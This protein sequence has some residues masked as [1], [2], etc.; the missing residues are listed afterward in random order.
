MEGVI[1]DVFV[2][3]M[4]LVPEHQCNY[5]CDL[6]RMETNRNYYLDSNKVGGRR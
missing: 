3:E 2:R 5:K 6:N 4:E 1:F